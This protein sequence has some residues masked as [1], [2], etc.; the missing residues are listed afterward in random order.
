MPH[1]QVSSFRT[2]FRSKKLKTHTKDHDQ[3]IL[4]DLFSKDIGSVEYQ[5][6]S[7]MNNRLR[8]QLLLLRQRIS[9]WARNQKKLGS[10]VNE[11]RWREIQEAF[12]R[13]VRKKLDPEGYSSDEGM[14]F[15]CIQ[16]IR[17]Q[18]DL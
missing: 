9:N 15:L 17:K 13:K 4:S 7:Y 5:G 14:C 16:L 10:L 6:H 3:L 11:E 18:L 12:P 8:S 2:L 1:V